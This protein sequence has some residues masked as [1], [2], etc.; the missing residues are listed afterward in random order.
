[1]F[2]NRNID[3]VIQLA[4]SLGFDGIELMGREPHLAPDLPEQEVLRI[5]KLADEVKLP[6]VALATYTGYYSQSSDEQ[7]EQEIEKLKKYLRMA[8]I[9][10]CDLIRHA[11]GGPSPYKAQKYHWQKAVYWMSK[12]ADLAREHSKNLVMEIHHGSLI[13]TASSAKK[14]LNLV[15]RE[16]LGV[17][18]DPGNMYI[19][20]TDYGDRAVKKLNKRIFHVHIKDEKRVK[21]ENLPDLFRNVTKRGTDLI[22]HRLLGEGNVRFQPVLKALKEI[23]YTGYLSVESLVSN[24][25]DDISIVTHELNVLKRLLQE[26]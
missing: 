11:P 8:E 16:N 15:N 21:K 14:F 20:R 26:S 17:I 24:N 7:A 6:I 2:R 12:A 22:Q 23:G 5:K 4:S 18:Y 13:E 3:E 19:S 9:L 10:D 1:M 25:K